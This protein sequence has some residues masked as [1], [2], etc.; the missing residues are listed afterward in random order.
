LSF[1]DARIYCT[2][3]D[4]VINCIDSLGSGWKEIW[5]SNQPSCGW[6]AACNRILIL[7]RTFQPGFPF[8]ARW[9]V[10]AGDVKKWDSIFW[11]L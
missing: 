4:D 2:I 1:L 11:G 10:E 6:C 3:T 5:G 9:P 7:L 8:S